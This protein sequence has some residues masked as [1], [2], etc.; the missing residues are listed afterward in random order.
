MWRVGLSPR[1]E[2]EFDSQG[3]SAVDR[4][5]CPA[6]IYLVAR[7]DGPRPQGKYPIFAV[8][9][10]LEQP[11]HVSMARVLMVSSSESV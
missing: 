3:F 7:L 1:I 10:M 2:G 8:R 5:M 9:D 6:D 11:K 4:R